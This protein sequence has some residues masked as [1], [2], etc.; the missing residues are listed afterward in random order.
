MHTWLTVKENIFVLKVYVQP[1]AKTTEVSGL[2]NNALKIRL[3]APPVEGKANKA[4][5]FF[6]SDRLNCAKKEITIISGELSRYKTVQVSSQ[7][8]DQN[9]ILM[10]LNID[11]TQIT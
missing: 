9:R 6:L 5:I 8:V 4:L 10:A 3:A 1:G 11:E 2:Y 7:S